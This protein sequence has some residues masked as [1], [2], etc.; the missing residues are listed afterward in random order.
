MNKNEFEFILKEGEGLKSEFKEK[1]ADIDK[2]I[3][4]LANCSGGRIF[5]GVDDTGAVKGIDSTN[6]LTALCAA[7]LK[8]SNDTALRELSQ[9]E[10]LNLI[11]RKGIGRG[12]Y[13]V[14]A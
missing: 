3:V 11:L 2:E 6:K 13:Y 10:S 4:A 7:L 8:V 5:V 1:I 14:L 12:I 9:L